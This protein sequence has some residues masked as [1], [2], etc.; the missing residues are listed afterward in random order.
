MV[1]FPISNIRRPITTAT[2]TKRNTDKKENFTNKKDLLTYK[3]GLLPYKQDFL[4]YTKKDSLTNNKK[5][6]CKQLRQIPGA[7]TYDKFLR[8]I[9]TAISHSKFLWQIPTGN[10]RICYVEDV[11]VH[12]LC[13]RASHVKIKIKKL[14][15]QKLLKA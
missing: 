12:T 8:Q 5:S 13:K 2:I 10:F 1:Y 6:H 4:T 11:V 9:A 14:T 7:N 3:K 15:E